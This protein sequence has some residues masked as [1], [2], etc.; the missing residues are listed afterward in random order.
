MSRADHSTVATVRMSR[1]ALGKATIGA[2]AMAGALA[3]PAAVQRASAEDVKITFMH[4]G[5]E[6][7]RKVVADFI[8]KFEDANPGIKVDQQH[9]VDENDS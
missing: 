6:Q 4:W 7:E 9:V 1:R 2:G 5:S 3:A 8:K